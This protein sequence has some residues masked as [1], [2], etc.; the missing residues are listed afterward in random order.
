[1]KGLL[2]AKVAQVGS[3]IK[4]PVG[5]NAILS[6]GDE[7][8]QLTII[9]ATKPWRLLL[10]GIDHRCGKRCRGDNPGAGMV[11]RR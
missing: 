3:V 11:A 8:V 9:G 1:V 2:A 4:H 5:W 6:Y 7:L 10:A